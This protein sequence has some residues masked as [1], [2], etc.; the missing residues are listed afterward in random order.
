MAS[1]IKTLSILLLLPCLTI[2]CKFDQDG[3][4]EKPSNNPVSKLTQA[5]QSAFD[6]LNKLQ[7]STDEM[8]RIY[9]TFP[10]IE[11]PCYPA[12][13]NFEITQSELL[14]FMGE[15]IAK[16][17]QNLMPKEQA[18]LAKTA[19]LA[20]KEYTVLHCAGN[21]LNVNYEKGLPMTGTWVIPNVLG[22]RDVVLEW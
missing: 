2:A 17:C 19:V 22:R 1:I 10:G 9:S 12:D 3:N 5:Q 4:K 15:F 21:D 20:Q 11:Q 16:H 8:N 6:A 13:E 7:T 18:Q 14:G